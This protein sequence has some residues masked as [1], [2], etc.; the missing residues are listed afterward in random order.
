MP[1]EVHTTASPAWVAWQEHQY[2]ERLL[3]SGEQYDLVIFPTA[4]TSSDTQMT[5]FSEE[6]THHHHHRGPI[7]D[8]RELR[9]RARPPRR[10]PR[11]C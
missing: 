8:F 4:S 1:V 2:L 10:P 5:D 6:P 7:S 9:D 3:A 11:A